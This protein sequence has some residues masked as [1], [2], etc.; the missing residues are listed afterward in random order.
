LNFSS[1]PEAEDLHG[2]ILVD[3]EASLWASLKLSRLVAMRYPLRI[4]RTFEQQSGSRPFT[5]NFVNGADFQIPM[6]PIDLFDLSPSE[7]N[8]ACHRTDQTSFRCHHLFTIISP[9]TRTYV[10]LVSRIRQC[11]SVKC[12]L[13]GCATGSIISCALC[14]S[15]IANPC[16]GRARFGVNAAIWSKVVARGHCHET[17]DS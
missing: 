17:I 4:S 3:P 15:V 12:P 13:T 14:S 16:S 9:R 5:R 1:F 8:S 7:I 2:H 10:G 11:I 6:G